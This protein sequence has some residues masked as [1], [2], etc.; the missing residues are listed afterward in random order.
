MNKFI[1]GVA[2]KA[3]LPLLKV[4]SN[5]PALLFAGGVA[6]VVAT[7]V[8]A[9]RATL[10]ME[11]VL[12]EH[13]K[14]VAKIDSA[15]AINEEYALDLKAQQKDRVGV[16][17][18]TSLSVAKLYAPAVLVGVA[19]IAALTGSH[20]ILTNRVS[21]LTA[22]YATLDGAFRKY[23]GRVVNKYGKTVD[24]EMYF[25]ADTIEI[26]VEGEDGK[27]TKQKIRTALGPNGYAVCFDE[28]NQNWKPAAGM[29]AMFIQSQQQWANNR[30]R[31]EG[32]LFL[33]DVYEML[34]FPRTAAGQQVGWVKNSEIGDGYIDFG[35]LTGDHFNGLRFV[36]G[37]ERSVWLDFNVDGVIL[38]LIDKI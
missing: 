23:R 5:S 19:S 10:K 34:G 17:V 35:V 32:F 18:R 16:F 29:N 7:V 8:L 3:A 1:A 13:E 2:Q 25:G 11:G 21:G 12:E 9:S 22:A 31:L 20:V 6:G 27:K 14:N 15:A 37:D 36:N 24:E 30:L 38:D 26:E 33:N 4:K 28:S